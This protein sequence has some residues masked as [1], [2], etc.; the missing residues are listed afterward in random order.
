MLIADYSTYA[1][2][3]W[4]RLVCER[5]EVDDGVK[6]VPT[7]V[8]QVKVHVLEFITQRNKYLQVLRLSFVSPLFYK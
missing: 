1:R 2:D 7:R 8:L 5:A 3:T 4:G 6:S